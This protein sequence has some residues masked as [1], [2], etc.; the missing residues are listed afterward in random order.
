MK[1]KFIVC[2]YPNPKN[3]TFPS[4]G[5]GSSEKRIWQIAKT[6][7]EFDDFEVILTGP[8]W[9]PK[10]VPCAKH[11]KERL[12]INTVKKFLHRFGKCNFLFAGHE[13]FD[14]EDY[15]KTFKQVA[16][17]SFS[18]VLHPYN[19]K[20]NYFDRKNFF[21]FCYSDE[22]KDLY[23]EMKPMKQVLFHSGVDEQPFL[24]HKHS[25][26]L[27]WMGRI[28]EQKSPHYAI[29]AA[30][31][32]KM[33]LYILGK[34]VYETVYA[35]KYK[36]LLSN[37][38]VKKLGILFGKKKMEVISKAMCAIYTVSK[39]FID[40]GPGSLSEYL[41]SGIPL[42]GITWKGND[43]ICEAV[44]SPV[45]GKVVKVN[46]ELT[47]KQIGNLIA[48]A[49]KECLKLDRKTIFNQANK[50][51]NMRKILRKIFNLLEK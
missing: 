13:Y 16:W 43:A 32:L 6:V 8:L 35:Q 50:R 25:N 42:V 10:Y 40:A 37:K 27:V 15:V 51:Y 44:D 45:L 36:N 7:A 2:D 31:E 23:K 30:I 1:K 4:F 22:I 46:S 3:Y 20:K 24:N 21:L 41:C 26:Y 14:K 28:E 47:D 17:K 9:L 29:Y 38:Y 39:N 12:T 48:Q 33:P 11:F 19:F 5:F 18:Y 34:P 49:V